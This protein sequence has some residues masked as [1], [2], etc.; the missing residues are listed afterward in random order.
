MESQ[1]RSKVQE[2]LAHQM[3]TLCMCIPLRL[4]IWLHGTIN[5]VVSFF[6]VLFLKRSDYLIGGYSQVSRTLLATIDLSGVIFGVTGAVGAWRMD[7]ALVTYFYYFQI[8][9]VLAWVGVMWCD[10]S[11][12]FSCEQ[13]VQDVEWMTQTKGWNQEIF[14]VAISE[15]CYTRRIAFVVCSIAV[16]LTLLYLLMATKSFLDDQVEEP[17]YL[18]QT[19]RDGYDRVF[20]PGRRP[21]PVGHPVSVDPNQY[22]YEGF[23][24]A[25][26]ADASRQNYEGYRAATSADATYA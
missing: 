11:L 4:G 19:R 26:N 10:L 24:A 3:H 14:S 7:T 16:L 9:R 1:K 5:V 22:T 6:C 15:S 8:F 2:M 23:R 21:A 13:W 12:L 18:L 25:R 20:R 17:K